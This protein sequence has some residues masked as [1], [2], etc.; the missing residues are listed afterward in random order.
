MLCTEYA[1]ADQLPEPDHTAYSVCRQD[2]MPRPYTNKNMTYSYICT[3]TTVVTSVDWADSL[4][5]SAR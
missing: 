4:D 1:S 3:A 5:L 2:F